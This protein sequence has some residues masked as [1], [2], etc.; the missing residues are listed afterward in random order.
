MGL[1]LKN[2]AIWNPVRKWPRNALCPCESGVKFKK[3]CLEK[4]PLAINKKELDNA[5]KA[6][7]KQQEDLKKL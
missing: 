4:I 6:A 2:G 3:C 5:I 7:K 1:I